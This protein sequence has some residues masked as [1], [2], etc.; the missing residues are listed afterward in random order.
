M[1]PKRRAVALAAA[2]CAC[3]GIS[4]G[5]GSHTAPTTRAA[6]AGCSSTLTSVAS[7]NGALTPGSTVCLAAGSYG[8][9]SITAA[10]SSNATLT[11][12]PGAKVTV[13]GVNVAGSNITVRGLY[14][15]GSI[16]VGSSGSHDVIEHNDVGPTGGYGISILSPLTAPSSDIT[17][18]WNKI[19]DTSTSGEGDAL[20]FDGWKN[21]SVIG[22]DIY[23]IKECPSACHTDTLQSYQAETPASGLVVE[24]NYVHDDTGV[25]GLPFLKD[26]D[27]QNV[28]IRDNLAVRDTSIGQVN[29]FWID[30]NTKGLV[31][32]NNTYPGL[33][34]VIDATGKEA[35]SSAAI[36]HNVLGEF[37]TLGGYALTEDYNIFTINNE[38][39]F[40]PGAHSKIEAALTFVNTATDDY[41]LKTNPNGIGIDWAPAEQQYGPTS[42][43]VESPTAREV[44]EREER[45]HEAPKPPAVT[46]PSV[47]AGVTAA[48]KG[49]SIVVSWSANA[50]AQKVTAY[51]L[52]RAGKNRAGFA[53]G[54]PWTT[55]T[56]T[57]LTNALEVTKG[58][59][60][61][62]RVSATNAQGEGP[63][64]GPACATAE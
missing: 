23:N 46:K 4:I 33:A 63:K 44:Q 37:N 36:D 20:R 43:E 58:E 7:V 47:P 8:Q 39:T 56:L 35:S 62:F 11:A 17:I 1:F 59:W 13:N 41:R 49:T 5:C 31:V 26:G 9:V 55:T 40:K 42:G 52:F 50:A 38:W 21:V 51:S 2:L 14:S 3:A 27:V 12:V 15:T 30:E 45:E 48:A 22:N 64:S 19:H 28:T 54:A 29:G 61:C 34:N 57:T 53:V 60:L 6:A 24:R 16:N 25:Q 10:P 18:A 32:R